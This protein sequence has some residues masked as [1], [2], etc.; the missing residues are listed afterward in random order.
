MKLDAEADIYV[1]TVRETEGRN[2]NANDELDNLDIRFY[3]LKVKASDFKDNVTKLIES[4]IGG[5][6]NSTRDSQRRSRKAQASVDESEQ[7]VKESK[8]LRKKI[9][10]EIIL[11]EPEFE[12][13]IVRLTKFLFSYLFKSIQ[14]FLSHVKF[15]VGHNSAASPGILPL[16]C[17]RALNYVPG[18]T[19][20]M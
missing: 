13:R 14:L 5:A 10:K 17:N 19:K 8:K 6:L 12:V 11:G 4:N 2:K 15:G 9:K 18:T 20:R 1:K 16:L 7:K 3:N